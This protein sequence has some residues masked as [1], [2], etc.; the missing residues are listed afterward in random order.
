MGVCAGRGMRVGGGVGG[1]GCSEGGLGGESEGGGRSV[2]LG[3]GV[4]KGREGF[5]LSVE[6][7]ASGSLR[8]LLCWVEELEESTES[9]R[10]RLLLLL[11][12][13]SVLVLILVSV[14][15]G[16]NTGADGLCG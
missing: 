10:F 6:V 16:T 13:V 2:N 1:G 9:A 11:L 5:I 15:L 8:R 4:R 7:A 3:M 12:L 14:V